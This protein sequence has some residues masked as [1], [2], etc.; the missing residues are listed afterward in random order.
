MYFIFVENSQ[1]QPNLKLREVYE[2]SKQQQIAKWPKHGYFQVKAT[3]FSIHQ[4]LETTM[5]L[6]VTFHTSKGS[7]NGY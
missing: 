2:N 6:W 1:V 4:I 5:Q 7:V 3:E